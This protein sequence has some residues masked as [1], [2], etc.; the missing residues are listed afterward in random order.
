MASKLTWFLWLAFSLLNA[1]QAYQLP[2]SAERSMN[3]DSWLESE[4]DRALQS[5]LDNIGPTG[6]NAWKASSGVVVASPS[7]QDPNYYF[8]WT[9]DAA[10]VFQSIVDAFIQGETSL[11]S[12]IHEYISSQ[13]RIQLLLTPSGNLST[14]GLGEPKYYV[15]ETQFAGDW[16]RPQADGPALRATAMIAYARWLIENN[17]YDVAESIVWPVIRNDLSYVSQMWNETGFDIWEE[18]KVPSFFTTIVQHR[19]L[20]EGVNLSREF[21]LVCPNCASQAPQILCLL[22]S[23]WNGS[24]IRSNF[25]EGRSGI[26]SSSILGSILTFDPEGACDDTTYQPCSSRALANHK[27][28]T[29]VFRSIY[30]LNSGI[31]TGEAVAIGR[32][33]EDRYFNGNPWYVTTFAAA[34]QLY[35]AIHQ[36]KQLGR[37]TVTDVSL[38]F[39]RDIYRSARIGTY[40]F[41]NPQ[42]NAIIFAV[43]TYAD[44][45]MA[46]AVGYQPPTAPAISQFV[47]SAA[48]MFFHQQKYTPCSGMLSEQY[49][50]DKGTSTSASD[51][52]WSY[53]AFFTAVSRRNSIIPYSWGER[54]ARHV[55]RVC[56]P[57]S[58]TGPFQN[59]TI[60]TW[61]PNL[62]ATAS[63]PPCSMPT[64]VSVRFDVI[65]STSWEQ[66][67]SIVGSASELGSWDPDNAVPL[68][69]DQY[70]SS[71]NLWYA[72]VNLTAGITVEYKYIRRDGNG[73][74]SWENDPNRSYTV[75]KKCDVSESTKRDTWR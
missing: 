34:E 49:S 52:T 29:D 55:P 3:L 22:Q 50:R 23:Y 24:A 43:R 13:A 33:P 68:R 59:A 4:S 12:K 46:I 8:T 2:L 15:N 25:I 61:P 18:I 58:A 6:S 65:A 19:A 63:P 72:P 53:A 5:I 17:Y 44:G 47:L 40:W 9:R 60:T 51:L 48:N 31:R 16:G 38:P 41:F 30:R 42:F 14:G 70:S 62:T 28:T 57:T 7:T 66:T 45:F 67:I 75:P 74:V 39:F 10:I 32:Y 71:C 54:N 73:E 35:D 56:A 11:Q 64:T 36:W 26:D 21:G 37:I 27:L 1:V 69:A 20:V